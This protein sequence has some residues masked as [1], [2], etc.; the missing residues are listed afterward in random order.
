MAHR[1]GAKCRRHGSVGDGSCYRL[2]LIYLPMNSM[3]WILIAYLLGMLYLATR[4]EKLSDLVAFR[5]AWICF[6]LI[7]LSDAFLTV[8][9]AGN[10]N[11]ARDLA[12]VEIWA[13]GLA[14]AFF[15]LSLL[16]LGKSLIPVAS[17]PLVPAAQSHPEGK[18]P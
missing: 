7:P 9:R 4:R 3:N 18:Q 2:F 8:F 16:F 5:T 17:S 14:W 12:L 13:E 1:E 6:A 15:G 11:D 10:F